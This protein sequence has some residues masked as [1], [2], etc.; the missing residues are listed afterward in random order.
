MV[1]Y[2]KKI[3]KKSKSRTYKKYHSKTF[4][5]QIG[6]NPDE[7]KE[8]DPMKKSIEMAK[9]VSSITN[10]KQFSVVSRIYELFKDITIYSFWSFLTFPVYVTSVALN[11]PFN[12]IKNITNSRFKDAHMVNK[13]IYK[14]LSNKN[15]TGNEIK[16]LD[17]NI[18]EG[19][20][21]FPNGYTYYDGYITKGGLIHGGAMPTPTMFSSPSMASIT[22]IPKKVGQHMNTEAIERAKEQTKQYTQSKP[23]ILNQA[24]R[25][26]IGK[27]ID[28]GTM[29]S[30][31]IS[32]GKQYVSNKYSHAQQD[33]KYL[34]RHQ[35]KKRP[36]AS[37]ANQAR[38]MHNFVTGKRSL[39]VKQSQFQK[40]FEGRVNLKSKKDTF[41]NTVKSMIETNPTYKPS[42]VNARDYFVYGKNTMNA[43]YGLPYVDQ[44]ENGREKILEAEMR[45][46]SSI[47]LLKTL[48]VFKTVFNISE[49]ELP[50]NAS[51]CNNYMQ[52]EKQLMGISGEY[53]PTFYNPWP[54][55][56]V[57]NV[58]KYPNTLD[59]TKLTTKN[60]SRCLRASLTQTEFT[61]EDIEKCFDPKEIKCKDCTLQNNFI[62]ILKRIPSFFSSKLNLIGMINAL[63]FI[64]V[65]LYENKAYKDAED[66][67]DTHNST[68]YTT[69][70]YEEELLKLYTQELLTSQ[71]N[72]FEMIKMADYRQPLPEAKGENTEI[73]PSLED[74]IGKEEIKMFKD[75]MCRYRLFDKLKVLYEEKRKEEVK[76]L[77]NFTITNFETKET[78]LYNGLVKDYMPLFMN[79]RD[80]NN[81]LIFPMTE[82]VSPNVQIHISNEYIQ[83]QLKPISDLLKT[84]VK[85]VDSQPSQ[86]SQL[87]QPTQITQTNQP[88]LV[89]QQLNSQNSLQNPLQNQLQKISKPINYQ[90][91]NH[92]M[93]PL[94]HQ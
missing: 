79:T 90:N 23:T 64:L 68:K 62:Q 2:K 77:R 56:R 33:S 24:Y 10:P 11:S 91:S 65:N 61:D 47:D 88:P 71:Y 69:K 52:G 9:Q 44:G 46:L 34:F 39:D 87:T 75:L 37:L 94:I 48:I 14:L 8:N 84:Q 82:S 67:N 60:L 5:N 15:F 81:K 40:Y 25:G 53:I 93:N 66:N 73:I 59:Y 70:T 55:I 18:K 30:D 1:S 20:M 4:M 22:S 80:K 89:Q 31:K 29:V 51:S 6:G 85:T 16:V 83:Q 58:Y 17:D 42:E 36:G 38:L 13:P 57:K 76:K 41:S 35:T 32:Q 28:T 86:P 63:F 12:T 21:V 78:K 19:K 49:K 50:N 72:I 26:T 45:K 3:R 7:A 74:F 27:A 43:I 54:I 92:T